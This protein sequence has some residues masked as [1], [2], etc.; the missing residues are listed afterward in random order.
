[1]FRKTVIALPDDSEIKKKLQKKMH[2]YRKRVSKLK[3]KSKYSNPDL[4]YATIT[5]YKLIIAQRLTRYGRVDTGD[6]TQELRE[7]YGFI[8]ENAFNNAAGVIADYCKTGGKNVRNG[9][10]F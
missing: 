6:L 9:T 5:G 3:K 4:V 8:D 7:E 10:G 2:E 1:M